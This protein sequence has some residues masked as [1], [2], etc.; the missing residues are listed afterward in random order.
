[1]RK[2]LFGIGMF[3]LFAV[4]TTQCGDLWSILDETIWSLASPRVKRISG[5]SIPPSASLYRERLTLE[6]TE[7]SGVAYACAHDWPL[8]AGAK[9]PFVTGSMT[10]EEMILAPA[11]NNPRVLQIM[12]RSCAGERKT[13]AIGLG[14][15]LRN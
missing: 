1:M 10:D 11:I 8:L 14:P 6:P 3:L 15:N 4:S 7:D 9:R 5:F 12:F 2:I 13:A